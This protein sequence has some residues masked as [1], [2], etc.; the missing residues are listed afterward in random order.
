MR[1][2]ICDAAVRH[3]LDFLRGE[4]TILT[5]KEGSAPADP[6]PAL[7]ASYDR[8]YLSGRQ[9]VANGAQILFVRFRQK[10]NQLLAYEPRQ[11]ERSD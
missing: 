1:G 7:Y 3:L 2:S 5:E 8:R 10:R 6:S 4:R 11:H 9:E